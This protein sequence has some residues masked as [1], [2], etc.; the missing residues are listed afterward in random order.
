MLDY[1]DPTIDIASPEFAQGFDELSFWSARFGALLF[2]HLEVRRD[3]D[4]LD[5]GCATGFPL[6]ELANVHGPS[7]RLVG[8][9]LWRPALDRAEA[10]RRLY[11]LDQVRLVE[12]DAAQLPFADASFDLV[13]S[14]LGVNNFADP[15]AAFAE[16]AR[17]C[18]P[19]GRLVLTTNPV[20]HMRE[21]Y[22]VFRAVLTAHGQPEDLAR[23]RT[24]E[25][26]RGTAASI[27]ASLEGAGFGVERVFED[28][29]AFR[30]ADGSAFLRHVLVRVGFLE[31]WRKVV[32][33]AR[34]RTIFAALEDALNQRAAEGG[35]LLLTVPRL[36]L[37]ARRA[38][39]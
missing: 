33:P 36:Y 28:R 38:G 35:E 1:L 19:G 31:A 37:E 24:N 8:V 7:C 13:T 9:D 30:F 6:F 5:V 4:I 3:L 29:F 11:G 14:N 18:R 12:A 21:L 26:H 16:C 39:R 22:D 25:D 23:L 17:V 20:G 32:E 15:T 2:E 27:A 10:K 34:E